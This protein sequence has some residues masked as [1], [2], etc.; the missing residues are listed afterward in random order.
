M[1][2]ESCERRRRGLE[3]M[4][5]GPRSPEGLVAGNALI[6]LIFG[7]VSV[8]GRPQRPCVA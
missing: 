7:L 1:M 8:I 4:T 3:T 5:A 2:E 6:S